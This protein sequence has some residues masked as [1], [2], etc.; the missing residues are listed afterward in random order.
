MQQQEAKYA[1]TSTHELDKHEQEDTKTLSGAGVS[2]LTQYSSFALSPSS[3]RM[4]VIDRE[5]GGAVQPKLETELLE[6]GEGVGGAGGGGGRVEEYIEQRLP[7]IGSV[8]EEVREIMLGKLECKEEGGAGGGG[9]G[10]DGGCFERR[11]VTIVVQCCLNVRWCG[12]E[13]RP[14][15]Y[16]L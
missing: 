12:L 1:E 3:S 13:D 5:Q 2:H 14:I 15:F 4:A 6:R 9:G 11:D 7:G 10:G 8:T 16:Q